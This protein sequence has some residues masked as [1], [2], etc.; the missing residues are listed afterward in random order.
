MSS[1]RQYPRYAHEAALT[2]VAGGQQVTGTTSN[3][4]RGGVSAVMTA[5]I[6]VGTRG[7][8]ELA[9]VFSA[10]ELSEKLSIDARVV[11]CTA[12]GEHHQVGM[13]F[14]ALDPEQLQF[15]ELFLRFL[16]EGATQRRVAGTRRGPFDR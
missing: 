5:P 4:S 12:L 9:L 16:D 10:N 13:S 1:Q 11:W 2:L 15:L 3:L 6:R 8:L 14:G 7:A